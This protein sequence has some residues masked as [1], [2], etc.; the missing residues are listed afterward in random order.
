MKIRLRIEALSVE[1]F[2]VTPALAERRGT[3]QGHDSDPT[4]APVECY[5]LKESCAGMCIVYDTCDGFSC[6]G[7]CHPTNCTTTDP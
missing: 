5:S 7:T 2:E 4:T 6:N 3:V 1:S